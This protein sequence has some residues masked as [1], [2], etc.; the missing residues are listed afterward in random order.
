MRGRR[1][2]KLLTLLAV[3]GVLVLAAGCGTTSSVDEPVTPS[4]DGSEASAEGAKAGIG[5]TLKVAG[6]D[7]T[8]EITLSDSKRVKAVT[9]YGMEMSPAAYGVKLTIKNIGDALYDDSVLNCAALVDAKDETHEPYIGMSE[10]SGKPMKG[11]LDSIKVG[12]GDKRTGWVFFE[13]TRKQK[14]R[15]LQFT[16]DSGFGP[17]VGEWILK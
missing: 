8:L 6:M 13:M 9:S 17:E 2:A 16:A 1:T 7:T 3:L 15:Q 4:D 5:D 10:K 11:L 12:P 14:P